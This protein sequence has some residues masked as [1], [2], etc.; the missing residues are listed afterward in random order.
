MASAPA[1]TAVRLRPA[2]GVERAARAAAACLGIGGVLGS[3]GWLATAAAER[4]STLSPP[5]LRAPAGWLLGPLHGLLLAH[6]TTGTARLHSDMVVALIVAGAAWALAW[7]AA[8]GLPAGALLAGQR[9][10]PGHPRP[11][12][13]RCR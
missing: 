8:P 1:R 5:T 7:A 6:L 2:M 3:A 10:G 13:R 9:A 4:R 12:A 11:R